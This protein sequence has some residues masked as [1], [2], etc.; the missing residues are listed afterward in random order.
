M[1]NETQDIKPDLFYGYAS[2]IASGDLGHYFY[3]LHEN[4]F[5]FYED[6]YWHKLNEIQFLGEIQR[7]IIPLIK[8]PISMRKQVTENFKHLRYLKLEDLNTYPL[9]NFE[10][11]MYDPL[12]DNVLKHKPEFYSTIRI[13]YKYDKFAKCD[14]WVKTLNEIL[15]NNEDKIGLLQE[16]FGYCLVSDME[17]KKALLLL[18]ETDTGKS[19]ILFIL[20]DLLGQMNCSS[21]PL[22]YLP[23]PQYTPLLINKMVNI[24]SDVN[25][26]AGDYEREFKIITSG[27]TVSC[28]QKHIPTFE[29]IP[30]CKIILAA[31]IFPKITDHSSAFY[32][33]LLLIPCE[34][35]F[36]EAEK[37]RNLHG[38]L[39][40]ELSG[41]FNWA[42]EGLRRFKKRGQFIEHEFMKNAVQELKDENN[43]S[44]LFFDEHIEIEMGA[45]IEKG[46]MYQKYTEWAG[47]TKNYALSQNRFSTAVYKKY[48]AQTPKH[49]QLKDGGKRIW[50]NIKYVHFKS[51]TK[52]QEISWD[53]TP[54]VAIDKTPS[55]WNI[56]A[57]SQQGNI[58]WE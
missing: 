16:F 18:G 32:Q 39:K 55:P 35:R 51:E 54:A 2:R 25:K 43:P 9:I 33:R 36:S 46:E 40:Q 15:Q 13:P 47:R 48:Q 7:K 49:G 17:Q 50:K 21:V 4:Y 58:S 53:D 19:T 24:D 10:N 30:K 34:R 45:Y 11:Y 37:N 31:N 38:Q 56:G 23:N 3:S 6:G 5:Y 44:N 29:F 42:L 20:K 28:N 57:D 26:N 27:E 12:G 52:A 22:Q 14:L 8:F 41:I 1:S